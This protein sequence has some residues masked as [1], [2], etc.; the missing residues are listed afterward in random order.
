MWSAHLDWCGGRVRRSAPRRT[1]SDVSMKNGI[2]RVRGTSSGFPLAGAVVVPVVSAM[3]LLAGP[4]AAVAD[5]P[6]TLA[7]DR[8]S[9]EE[10]IRIAYD[11]GFRSE[12]SLL[13]ATSV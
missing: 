11:A 7:G 4:A 9:V 2:P 10:V 12:S 13:S 6:S 1:R 5:P 3:V 8:L